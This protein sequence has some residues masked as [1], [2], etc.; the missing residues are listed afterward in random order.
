M[1]SNV[2]ATYAPSAVS[3]AAAAAIP[4]SPSPV[5]YVPVHRRPSSETGSQRSA[6]PT[7]SEAS[8][9]T[10]VDATAPQPQ[11]SRVYSIAT[12]LLLSHEP[13]IKLISLDRREMLKEKFPEIVMNRKLRKATEFHVIQERAK[14]REQVQREAPPPQQKVQGPN[15]P[16][17]SVTAPQQQQQRQRPGQRRQ[18]RPI[19]TEKRRNASKVVSEASWR[20]LRPSRLTV[21]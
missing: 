12:L 20:T 5:K 19:G 4:R 16:H 10:L 18:A 13:E 7:P 11:K 6:S 3:Y 14:T 2:I 9:S 1:S 21:A 17:V 8:T 15:P